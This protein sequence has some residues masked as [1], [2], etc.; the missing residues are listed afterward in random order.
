MRDETAMEQTQELA[1]APAGET[2]GRYREV[3]GDLSAL[4]PLAL[5]L[6]KLAGARDAQ[7]EEFADL[8]CSDAALSDELLRRANAPAYGAASPVKTLQQALTLVG[9]DELRRLALAAALDGLALGGAALD[10]PAPDGLALG[11]CRRHSL[12]VALLAEEMARGCGVCTER[13]Y[14]AGALHDIGLLAL[15][16][17]RPGEMADLLRAAASSPAADKAGFL[18]AREAETFGFDHTQ[19]GRWLAQRWEMPLELRTVAGQ[20]HERPASGAPTLLGIVQHAVLL[21]DALGLGPLP[22]RSGRDLAALRAAA[23][24]ELRRVFDPGAEK[25][26][27]MLRG[28]LAAL[29][30]FA[31]PEEEPAA[32]AEPGLDL[33]AEEEE[34]AVDEAGL[35]E[36]RARAALPWAL[37]VVT[38][39][40]AALVYLALQA[41]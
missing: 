38:G 29:E 4:P 10:R 2:A 21:A 16:A 13:A 34:P 36:D 11:R 25:L 17:A 9:F 27:A 1:H 12:A 8:P 26:L 32:E 35:T 28:R 33:Q 18:L 39:L 30:G 31:P 7:I 40:L 22:A 19:A 6:A 3:L 23:P 5:R 24:A 41:S 20:H 15:L 37:A 14:T